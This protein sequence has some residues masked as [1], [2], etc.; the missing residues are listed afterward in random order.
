MLYGK[1]K[2]PKRVL[3]TSVGGGVGCSTSSAQYAIAAAKTGVNVVLMDAD[4][5]HATITKAFNATDKSGLRE[6]I[7]CLLLA[8]DTAEISIPT[9]H[10]TLR[11]VPAGT[12]GGDGV[13]DVPVGTVNSRL[14]RALTELRQDHEVQQ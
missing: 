2:A 7:N 12:A 3:F 8:S 6:V 1:D 4:L 11:L 9:D 5:R 10:A 14:A 13:T